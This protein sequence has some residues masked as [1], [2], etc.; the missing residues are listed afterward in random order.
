MAD[1]WNNNGTTFDAIRMSVTDTTSGASSTLLNLLRNGVAQFTVDKNGNVS[2]TGT[3]IIFNTDISTKGLRAVAQDG[4]QACAIITSNPQFATLQSGS[5][6]VA[7]TYRF[8]SD[9]Q[10]G[11][12]SDVALM[13]SATNTIDVVA[14]ATGNYAHIVMF[15]NRTVPCAFASL[16]SATSVSAGGRALITNGAA[17]TFNTTAAGGG[18]NVV[19]VFSDG[20]QWKVG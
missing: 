4:L 6:V 3:Q 16:P 5:G 2:G 1:T 9:I 13:R 15:T 19:P 11:V 14:T 17:A 12:A 8:S 18:A 7:N 10:N 20:T